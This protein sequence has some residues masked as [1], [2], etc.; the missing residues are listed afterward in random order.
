MDDKE[1]IICNYCHSNVTKNKLDDW[2]YKNCPHY[3]CTRCNI[4]LSKGL[5][6]DISRDNSEQINQRRF[7]DK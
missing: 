3:F 7:G 5:F 1:L 2:G 4:I 6:T